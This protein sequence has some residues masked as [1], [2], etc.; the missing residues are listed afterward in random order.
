[1]RTVWL[2]VRRVPLLRMKRSRFGICS[3]SDGTLGLSRRK[4][5]VIE[6]QI[7][8]MLNVAPGRVELTPTGRRRGTRVWL[9]GRRRLIGH[10][11][12][13]KKRGRQYQERG[14]KAR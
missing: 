3:R 1:M 6:N 11:D 13:G 8:D 7:D 9:I 5:D 10:R 2:F 14:D 4:C 12:D